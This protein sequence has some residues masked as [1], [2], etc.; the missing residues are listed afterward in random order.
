MNAPG[1]SRQIAA[2]EALLAV[3]SNQKPRP[4]PAQLQ[5]LIEDARY[6]LETLRELEQRKGLSA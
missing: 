3:L 2:V 4:K 6:A 5:M 1:I